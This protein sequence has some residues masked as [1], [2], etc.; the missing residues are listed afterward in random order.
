MDS[1]CGAA[2]EACTWLTLYASVCVLHAAAG[3]MAPCTLSM[4]AAFEMHGVEIPN[5]GF[6]RA[7]HVATINN[8]DSTNTATNADRHLSRIRLK[9]RR[10]LAQQT[11][12]T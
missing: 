5:G 7:T 2:P 3:R 9:R 6:V 12:N 1:K 11:G 8:W 4:L 10:Q